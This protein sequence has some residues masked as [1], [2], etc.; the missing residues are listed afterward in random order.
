[1]VACLIAGVTSA[2]TFMVGGSA[3]FTR[4]FYAHA[5]PNRSHT[6]YLW[7]G[8]ASAGGLLAL[9][10]LAGT[11]SGKWLTPARARL[12]QGN[13]APGRSVLA[14]RGLEARHCSRSLGQ[15]SGKP[16]DLGPDE[17]TSRRVSRR[18]RP[19]RRAP[20]DSDH[21]RNAIRTAG[22][23]KSAHAAARHAQ[24]R[25]VLRTDSHSGRQGEDEVRWDDPPA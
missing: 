6:H 18:R 11:Q 3:L 19:E 21:V 17:R 7:V 9:G 15:L 16:P 20:A 1:M 23:G 25:P 5:L 2:E 14:G 8:R 4:N 13:R 12:G 10:I 22:S 24:A